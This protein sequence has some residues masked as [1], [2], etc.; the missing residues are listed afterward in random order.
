MIY[1]MSDIH[2]CGNMYHE[3]LRK[4]QFCDSDHLYILGDAID[5]GPDGI[6][7]LEDIMRRRNV[8]MLLGNHEHMMLDAIFHPE[9][10]MINFRWESNGAYPTYQSF[11]LLAKEK[12][13]AIL[14]FLSGLSLET[15]ISCNG[16]TYRL[17][18][19]APAY[20]FEEYNHRDWDETTFCVWYRIRKEALC[21]FHP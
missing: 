15:T 21:L 9:D 5:R 8:T 19:A 1:V 4:I 17:V 12:Q 20:M 11:C 6:S 2:G 16:H 10:D 7:I 3:M 14:D 18:H 13:E